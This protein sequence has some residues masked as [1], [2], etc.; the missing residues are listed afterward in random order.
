LIAI[1]SARELAFVAHATPSR[2]TANRTGT[3]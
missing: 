2:K 3:R 1:G